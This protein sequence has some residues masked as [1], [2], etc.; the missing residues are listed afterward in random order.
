[1][2]PFEIYRSASGKKSEAV[3]LGRRSTKIKDW[4]ILVGIPRARGGENSAATT[5]GSGSH[6]MK[7]LRSSGQER[8]ASATNGR[9]G[10]H[11]PRSG[12]FD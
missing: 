6:R 4:E 9:G 3:V 12:D 1:V 7:K 2:E 8:R 11:C 10:G 5:Q